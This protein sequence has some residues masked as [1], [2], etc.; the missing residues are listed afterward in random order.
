MSDGSLRSHCDDTKDDPAYKYSN[1]TVGE[2]VW[3]GDYANV[4][5]SWATD[6]LGPSLPS[7]AEAMAVLAG[8]TLVMSSLDFPFVHF[9][10][11]STHIL[12]IPQYQSFSAELTTQDF[13]SGGT[14]RWQNVFYIVLGG[15]FATNILCLYYLLRYEKLVIDFIEPQSLFGLSLNSPP[16]RAMNGKCGEKTDE[17]QLQTSWH[18][19]MEKER[20]LLYIE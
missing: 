10:N 16:N 7:I 14:E 19:K 15:I 11:Y 18:I 4:V 20:E 6:S 5:V 1:H 9:W 2:M 8:C 3:D 13:S 17:D 12:E